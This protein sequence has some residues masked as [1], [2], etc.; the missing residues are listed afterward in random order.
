LQHLKIF[1]VDAG[2]LK[3]P[4]LEDLFIEQKDHELWPE[5]RCLEI[6]LGPTYSD[7]DLEGLLTRR[8]EERFWAFADEA[9]FEV[10]VGRDME[11]PEVFVEHH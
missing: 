11:G 2:F 10:V 1:D 4:W 5:L 3:S 8:I 7:L 6:L 9:S